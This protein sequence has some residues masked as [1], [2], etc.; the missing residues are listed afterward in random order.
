MKHLKALYH[1]Y[2]FGCLDFI[3]NKSPVFVEVDACFHNKEYFTFFENRYP[4]T[5]TIL[6]CG[7]GASPDLKNPMGHMS[8]DAHWGIRYLDVIGR[9]APSVVVVP[10]VLGD[11]EAT[12]Q[13]FK[14]YNRIFS[15]V[16]LYRFQMMYVIQGLIKDEALYFLKKALEND[17]IDWIGFPRIVQYYFGNQDTKVKNCELAQRRIEFLEQIKPL[18]RDSEKQIHMLGMSDLSEISYAA[19]NGYSI[20]TRYA[21]MAAVAG[22]DVEGERPEGLNIDLAQPVST[23]AKSFTYLNMKKLTEIYGRYLSR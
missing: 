1:T 21:S 17:T 13:N 8:T 23:T 22:I 18:L 5:F 15:R 10:D 6:D 11:G 19:Q 20:D 14:L 7:V 16:F 12:T 2:P 9:I 3:Q 4:N